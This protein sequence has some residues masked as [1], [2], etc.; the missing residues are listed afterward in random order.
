M[1]SFPR[2]M[3]AQPAPQPVPAYANIPQP[4][5][6]APAPTWQP[7]PV[8]AN[9]LPRPK[10]RAVPADDPPARVVLPSPEAL[11][12]RTATA[13]GIDWN[14]THARLDRLQAV[15]FQSDRLPQGGYRVTF[16]LPA[17]TQSQPVE[18]VGETE[19]A[20]VQLALARAEAQ[21]VAGR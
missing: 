3:F 8:A 1:M 4:P 13:P 15:R 19:A 9:G 10:V 2:P 11:G 18:A 12:I 16:I 6:P 20:A 7:A 14:V 5:R 17:G 21:A